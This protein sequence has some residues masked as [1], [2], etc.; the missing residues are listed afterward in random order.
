MKKL[1]LLVGGPTDLWPDDLKAGRVKG[2]FIGIDRGNLRLIK[3]GIDPIVAIGDFDSL[4][5]DEF[6]LVKEHVADIRQSIPEKD[7]T[8]TQ[9]GLKVALDEYHADSIDIYGATGGRLDHF[10]AN[11]W[12]VLEPRFKRFAP[13]I[14]MVDRQNTITFFLPGKHTISK[15]VDKKYLA[16]VCLT[17][18]NSLTLYDEK[19]QLNNYKVDRPISW[20]SNEFIQDTASFEFDSGVMAVIQSKDLN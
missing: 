9:L 16:F 5:P 10:L 19:Y 12:M 4:Q 7:D 2:D 18:M 15:E 8:D 13:K 17:P 14:R 20:A 3:L 6:K 11:L 1:N